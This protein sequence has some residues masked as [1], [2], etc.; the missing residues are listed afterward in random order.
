[1]VAQHDQ[2]ERDT[3]ER[4][5]SP[6]V[7]RAY[8]AMRKLRGEGSNGI[9]TMMGVTG[10]SVQFRRVGPGITHRHVPKAEV[11]PINLDFT[12]FHA[13]MNTFEAPEYIDIKRHVHM[14]NYS[15]IQETTDAIAKALGRRDDQFILDAFD[16]VAAP[17]R[18]PH[19]NTGMTVAKM[20]SAKRTLDRL[21]VEESNRCLVM[22]ADGIYD[23][24][25]IEEVTSADYNTIR[26]LV[27]TKV[28]SYLGFE[29]IQLGA[30]AEGGLSKAGD[31]RSNWVFHKGMQGCVAAGFNYGAMVESNY[32]PER[33]SI[34]VNGSIS[35]GA[36]VRDTQGLVEIQTSEA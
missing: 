7:K 8:Q 21:E 16:A 10:S 18:V 4:M 17:Q 9:L 14:V 25:G 35:G 34:L 13:N 23:L 30:R 36:V 28:S 24:L 12:A 11:I 33:S 27:N 15:Q 2:I 3:A 19:G 20:R 5:Y 22:Y 32:V 26:A 31:I 1:M 29:I 6:M